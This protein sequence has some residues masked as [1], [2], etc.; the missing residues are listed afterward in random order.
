[1]PTKIRTEHLQIKLRYYIQTDHLGSG[2]GGMNISHARP[3][4]KRILGQ[5]H[6][7]SLFHKF[8]FNITCHLI[9]SP[10]SSCFLRARPTKILH[11]FLCTIRATY[12]THN[13]PLVFATYPILHH[14]YSL[15]HKHH[16]LCLLY[17]EI[18]C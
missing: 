16:Q 13:N 2:N 6:P 8:N 10:T 4:I 15:T 7:L 14:L 5:F 18:F 9:S 11:E 3:L 17:I 12:T 1:V